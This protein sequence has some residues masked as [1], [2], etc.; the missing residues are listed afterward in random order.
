[1]MNCLIVKVKVII[2]ALLSTNIPQ[3]AFFFYLF[4]LCV[5]MVKI[6]MSFSYDALN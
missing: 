4:I 5:N 3:R 2:V 6:C 1:M